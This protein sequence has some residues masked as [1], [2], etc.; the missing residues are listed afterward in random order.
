[1][2]FKEKNT[3]RVENSEN[4]HQKNSERRFYYAKGN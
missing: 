4:H 3:N 2:E 1:M